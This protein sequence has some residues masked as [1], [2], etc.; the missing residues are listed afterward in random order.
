MSAYNRKGWTSI[1]MRSEDGTVKHVPVKIG[2][3]IHKRY[4]KG[5]NKWKKQKE[6]NNRQYKTMIKMAK[7][8][9]TENI[10]TTG[11]LSE[12]KTS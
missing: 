3:S 5:Y 8:L 11:D 6:A 7:K 9:G 4:M 1:P 10:Q 12:I 2:S